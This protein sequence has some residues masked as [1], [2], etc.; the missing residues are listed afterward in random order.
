MVKLI[1]TKPHTYNNKV[2][3]TDEEF[4][5]D[6]PFASTLVSLNR[7]RR[8]DE[9]STEAKPMTTED[10]GNDDTGKKYKTRRMKAEDDDSSSQ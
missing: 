7:A 2:I 8:A 9:S 5:A 1:A 6:E 3:Q 4:E 10:N